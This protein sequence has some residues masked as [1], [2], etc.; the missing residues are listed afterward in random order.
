[1]NRLDALALDCWHWLARVSLQG[2]VLILLV[3]AVQWACR[4]WMSPAWRHS[5]WLLVVARLV[6]PASLESRLSLFNWLGLHSTSASPRRLAS[7]ITISET[8]ILAS[9]P[10]GAAPSSGPSGKGSHPSPVPTKISS[11]KAQLVLNEPSASAPSD[12]GWKWGKPVLWLSVVWLAGAIVLSWRVLVET[13][14]LRKSIVPKRLVTDTA[15]LEL[16]EDCKQLMKVQAPIVL[17][18]TDLVSTPV[19]YGF[20]RPRLLMP[21][22]MLEKLPRA[23]L[24]FVFLHELAHIHRHDI[25]VSWL[26]ALLQVLHWF[27]PLVWLA[28]ARMRADRELACDALVLKRTEKADQNA[29]GLTMLRLVENF[30]RTAPLPQ[31]VGILEDATL[32]QTRIRCIAAFDGRSPSPLLAGGIAVVLALAT[33]TDQKAKGSPQ[34]ASSWPAQVLLLRNEG[35]ADIR[36]VTLEAEGDVDI[37][38]ALKRGELVLASASDYTRLLQEGYKQISLVEG[39]GLDHWE[40]CSYEG[41]PSPRTGHSVVWTGHKLLVW[42]GGARN[43]FKR[44]GA[45]YNPATDTWRLISTNCPLTGRWHHAAVWTGKQMLVW[46]G[47][48][49]FFARESRGD[50]ARYDP[51]TDTWE[52]MSSQGAPTPRSQ[53]AAVWTGHELIIWGGRDDGT[54]NFNDGARYNP[55]TDT[56]LDMAPAPAELEASH[57]ATSIWTGKEMIVWGGLKPGEKDWESLGT[58]AR[59]DPA[60]DQWRLLPTK[61]APLARNRHTAVWTG[62]EM[63]IWG[64]DDYTTPEFFN[65][66][67]R[68]DPQIDQWKPISSKSAPEKRAGHLAAWTGSDMVVWGGVIKGNECLNTGGRYNATTDQWAALATESAPAPR[69]LMRPDAA[70]W[71]GAQLLVFGGY[72]LNTEFGSSHRWSPAQP[73]YLYQR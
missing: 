1:V 40:R 11:P 24:R 34:S 50:G 60:L 55:E 38:A 19:L 14:R 22:G 23:D 5:L 69:F 15:V 7:P 39:L 18:R 48:A 51:E 17:V 54:N 73:M 28:F 20:I 67:A 21:T 46:G 30:V 42:G 16:L 36:P 47:R 68:Y 57:A 72:D 53:M 44:S 43:L 56:W 9:T 35:G 45:C 27:N 62:T 41:A 31:M 13:L 49:H 37:A 33:L 8:A 71:T 10:Q 26:M 64:G 25:A 52:P 4:R 12:T 32:L 6:M 63:I 2:S 58:G 65:D 70:I 29:Y 61:G 3:L 59:Y 66:G